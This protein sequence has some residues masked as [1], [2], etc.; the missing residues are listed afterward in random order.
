MLKRS[1]FKAK[2]FE[3]RPVKTLD[4]YTPRP[5][6]VAVAVRD[7]SARMVVP[8]P[9]ENALQHEGYMAIVRR[10][11][12]AHCGRQGPS[13]FAHADEG[14]G[15]AIKTDCRRGWPGCADGPGR[16]GC[17]TLLGSTG[18]F[19]RDQRRHLEESH[20]AKTRAQIVADGA[21]PAGL[22]MWV[23]PTN[24]DERTA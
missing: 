15:L 11:P 14:K 9:K 2:G 5:R 3:P 13:Q 1:P 8:V 4:G 24:E 6:A 7:D 23:E 18:T 12:C 10:M 20:G 19:T 21:W 16:I 17:H 22:P